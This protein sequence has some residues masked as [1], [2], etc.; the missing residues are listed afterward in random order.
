MGRPKEPP[1]IIKKTLPNGVERFLVR[2]VVMGQDRRKVV[3]SLDE[4]RLI[5]KQWVDDGKQE[6]RVLQ[7]RL[8]ADELGGAEAMQRVLRT[9]LQIDFETAT[10]WLLANY[11]R[12]ASIEWT[13]AIPEYESDRRKVG[14]TESQISNV[15]KAAKRFAAFVSRSAVGSPTRAEVEG[16][17]KTLSEDV[18]P[19]TY[20]GLLSDVSAFL[21]WLVT[22]GY[23]PENPAEGMERR[24][25]KRGKPPVLQPTA[26]ETL[27]RD[28]EVNAPEW[29]PYAAC[30][31]FGALRPGMREGE[32]NRLDADLRADKTV[33][34]P[35]GIEVH[36]KAH[37]D[38]I[39]PWK[40][41]GPLKEWLDA[42]P[43][44]R[45]LWPAETPR[46]AD[47]E[48]SEFRAKHSFPCADVLRHTAISAMCY[49]TGASLAKVAIGTGTSESRIRTNYL[50]RW[51]EELTKELW[52][53]KPNRPAAVSAKSH[54]Q[55]A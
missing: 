17:L 49:A 23:L 44:N 11:K 52:A 26:V 19:S 32:A 43:P 16:L 45:G 12:P 42:Y 28:L 3:D 8:T 31:V 54:D 34:H 27:L 18:G 15:V 4:A 6:L 33:L 13:K 36:G 41:C 20:N 48:W 51:S 22:K 30:C 46:I 29:V 50:G 1:K 38:R 2:W 5:A 24:K 14:I 35:G 10:A 47:R 37:G 53:L 9:V 21:G 39:L 40:L 55:A 7:T 25:V